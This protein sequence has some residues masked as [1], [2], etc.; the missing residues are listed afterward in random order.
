MGVKS[1]NSHATT[2]TTQVT[3]PRQYD[4]DRIAEKVRGSHRSTLY[5]HA[6]SYALEEGASVDEAMAVADFIVKHWAH[7]DVPVSASANE[8]HFQ[9]PGPFHDNPVD[10]GV[11]YERKAPCVGAKPCN[12]K[13]KLSWNGLPISI[14]T[15]KGEVRSGKDKSGKTWSQEMT[16][17]Y[18]Y[19][20][21]TESEADGDHIDIFL[22]PDL[23][24]DKVFVINQVDPETKKFDEHKVVVGVPSKDAAKKL[25]LSNYEPGWMGFGSIV[26]MSLERLKE[27][28]SAGDTAEAVHYSRLAPA[29][30]IAK[31]YGGHS[32]GD[33]M[34][35]PD[36]NG[37]HLAIRVASV[38][39]GDRIQG[40]PDTDERVV[41]I[42][43]REGDQFSGH[44]VYFRYGRGDFSLADAQPADDPQ[45]LFD[46]ITEE[47][48]REPESMDD[49]MK[50]PPKEEAALDDLARRFLQAASPVRGGKVTQH[51]RQAQHYERQEHVF[52]SMQASLDRLAEKLVQ[53]PAPVAAPSPTIQIHLPESLT[54]PQPIY[55]APP[56]DT[57]KMEAIA[58]TMAAQDKSKMDAIF[59]T[60]AKQTEAME[61]MAETMSRP[62]IVNV[63][64]PVVNIV[65]RRTRKVVNRDKEGNIISVEEQEIE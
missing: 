45:A 20:R 62:P 19:I 63:P 46:L 22:G 25:Y 1:C 33:R 49:P 8:V 29:E 57:S 50:T 28:L 51:A 30:E 2:A 32:R 48:H 40:D 24:I 44:D 54:I 55:N 58:E 41:V 5:A 52:S 23:S 35:V 60:L 6:A 53:P 26:E 16:S 59:E 3:L 10:A 17:D 13:K 39:D 9:E 36:G 38:T 4:A 12:P 34:Y 11:L 21:K 18:G 15:Q 56:Q 61:R 42:D 37:H 7:G 64:A 47:R 14:E 31:I 43:D 65:P 27:W